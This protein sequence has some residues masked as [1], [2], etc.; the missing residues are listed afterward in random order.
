M[1]AAKKDDLLDIFLRH[2]HDVFVAYPLAGQTDTVEEIR[3]AAF[4]LATDQFS[5]RGG[6]T[7]FFK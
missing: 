4:K 5:E 3:D 1:G 6:P 7:D 2:M